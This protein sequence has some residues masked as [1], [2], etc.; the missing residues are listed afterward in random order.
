MTG[1]ALGWPRRSSKPPE[2]EPLGYPRTPAT[3]SSRGYR[4]GSREQEQA[5]RG[6]EPLTSVSSELPSQEEATK[7]DRRDSG[8]GNPKPTRK[9][10][11]WV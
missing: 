4:Y 8:R 1:G 7:G 2:T 9:M 11:G 5:L 6:Q 10:T 3:G